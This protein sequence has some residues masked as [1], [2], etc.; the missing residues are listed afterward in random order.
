MII[1]RLSKDIEA[2]NAKTFTPEEEYRRK[3]RWAIED[4]QLAKQYGIDAKEFT[5]EH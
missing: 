5:N 1:E 2:M 4:A 3:A